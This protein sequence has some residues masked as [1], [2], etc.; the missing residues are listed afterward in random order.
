[1]L[2]VW[3]AVGWPNG[4]GG[5]VDTRALPP[6][7][8]DVADWAKGLAEAGADGRPKML[9]CEGAAGVCPNELVVDGAEDFSNGLG[10]AGAE[11]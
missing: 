4:F 8:P 7:F 9:G 5:A 2:A 3:G 1:M 11:V 10:F 6:G